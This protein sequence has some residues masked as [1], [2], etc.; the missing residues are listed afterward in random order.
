MRAFVLAAS[1]A[2]LTATLPASAAVLTIGGSF[3]EGC[4]KFAESKT[5]TYDAVQTC[6]RAFAE[7]ALSRDDEL[8][9][10]VNRGIIKMFRSDYGNSAADFDR[11]IAMDPKR[12]EPW[13][14]KAILQFRQGDSAGAIPLFDKAIQLS[15]DHAEV[16]YYGRALANEDMGNLKAAYLDLKQAQALRPGWDA[17]TKDLARYKVSRP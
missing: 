3:A 17:P 12:S 2:A 16:A 10:Y 8:A 6:D 14:N 9:T 7:Q 13:L 1:A 5:A 4:Y 15:S 11:A